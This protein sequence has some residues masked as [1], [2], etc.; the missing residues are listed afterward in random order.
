MNMSVD[1]A[2]RN[3]HAFASNHFGSPTD[4]DRS[5]PAWMSGIAGIADPEMRPSL[6]PISALTIPQWS[7]INALV[8]T[9]SSASSSSRAGLA[10]AIANDFAAAEF[11]FFA[12]DGEVFFD[13]DNELGVRQAH[14]VADRGS[15]HF[16][17]CVP[18]QLGWSSA[19]F[20]AND[21]FPRGRFV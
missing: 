21:I 1:A 18:V 8:M 2:G 7:R 17:I 19:R 10:H 13:F 4:H 12:V 6:M 14:M 20:P 5:T 16:H 9:V 15:E 11:H 3:D